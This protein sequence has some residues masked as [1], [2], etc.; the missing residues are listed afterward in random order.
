[1][2]CVFLPFRASR[3]FGTLLPLHSGAPQSAGR[4][5]GGD[6]LGRFRFHV[7][8]GHELLDVPYA[9]A[10][11]IFAAFGV[12]DS[13]GR[14]IPLRLPHYEVLLTLSH[15]LA[16][17]RWQQGIGQTVRPACPLVLI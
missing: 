6:A 7:F 15:G 1:V 16:L 8:G 13:L 12:C 4:P 9:T 17:A 11:T 5:S 10:E 14:A 3:Y 2:V